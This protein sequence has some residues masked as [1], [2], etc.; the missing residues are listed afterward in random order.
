[1]TPD[2]TAYQQGV[3]LAGAALVGAVQDDWPA[4]EVALTRIGLE[5]GGEGMYLALLAWCDALV[6]EYQRAGIHTE[7]DTRVARP[8]WMEAST[9]RLDSDA[10]A[11]PRAVRW[12]GQLITARTALDQPAYDALISA[13]PEDPADLSEHINTLLSMVA[14]TIHTLAGAGQ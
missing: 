12:A 13:L 4:V 9:G 6:L 2:S 5:L 1:M 8:L 11:V 10:S 3:A 14:N 7:G